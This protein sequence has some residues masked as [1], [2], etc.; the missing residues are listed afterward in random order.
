M[1]PYLFGQSLMEKKMEIFEAMNTACRDLPDG[2]QIC[3]YMEN[4]AAWVELITPEGIQDVMHDENLAD[5]I[6]AAITQA[7]SDIED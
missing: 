7:H 1:S 6:I 2:Y 4:G 3:L 5:T